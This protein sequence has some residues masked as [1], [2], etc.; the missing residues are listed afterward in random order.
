ML[1]DELDHHDDVVY[2]IVYLALRNN[3]KL[4]E[5]TRPHVSDLVK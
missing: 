1:N 4:L 3:K 5:I 2:K